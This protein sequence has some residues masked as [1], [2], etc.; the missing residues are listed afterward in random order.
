[1]VDVIW[2][3]S[4]AQHLVDLSPQLGDAA[5]Q[6][7]PAI[8]ENNTV[9]GALV[10][11]PWFGDFGMLYYRT[12]LLQKAGFSAPPKTWDELEQQSNKIVD[13]EKA[14]NPNFAGF[15]YQGNAYE[16]LTCDAL[17]WTASAGGGTFVDSSGKV[18]INNPQA[19]AILNKM[20]GWVGTVSPRGVTSYQEE[21][22]RNA[23][24]GGNAAFMRNWPYAYANGQK[25][26]SPVKGKF[27]VAPL[28]AQSGSKPSGTVGGWQLSVSKYSKA[29]D[30]SIEFVRYAT[31]PE[32]QS[33]RAVVGTYVPT[34]QAV[35]DRPEVVTAMPFLKNLSSVDRVVRP[36]NA[37]GERYNEGSTAIFQGVNQI[38]NGQDA[39]AVLPQV[40]R[41]LERLLG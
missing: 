29:T 7:Y 12:D 27:D 36:S 18:T 15:V 3:S 23:F 30:A 37:L 8:V 17:E 20:K 31:S 21:E 5:K 13:G 41:Q 40:Q 11:M 1:M 19:V 9:K 35:A 16:G 34:I 22:A 39:S 33:Y 6:H 38:L 28:P 25:D 2:P 4:L 10:G 26:D 14:A 32:V 24:Q